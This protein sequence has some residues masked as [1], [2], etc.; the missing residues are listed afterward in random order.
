MHDSS[1]GYPFGFVMSKLPSHIFNDKATKG[2]P[3]LQ[4]NQAI[5]Q[6]RC[7]IN[8]HDDDLIFKLG[9]DVLASNYW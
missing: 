9:V 4:L 6:W 8:K 5:N 3:S 7:L 2:N 1:L